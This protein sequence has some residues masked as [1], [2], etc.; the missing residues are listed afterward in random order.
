MK[1][2][3]EPTFMIQSV[4]G[5]L[6]VKH[7]IAFRTNVADRRADRRSD[8]ICTMAV[9]NNASRTRKILHRELIS[10]PA[11]NHTKGTQNSLMSHLVVLRVTDGHLF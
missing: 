10:D 3:T 8:A 7:H 5:S 1:S 2:A 11:E 6:F 4:A 9:F